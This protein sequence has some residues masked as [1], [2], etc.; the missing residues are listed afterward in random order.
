[1]QF[2]LPLVTQ[3]LS[4]F[5]KKADELNQ[6]KAGVNSF[7]TINI[8]QDSETGKEKFQEYESKVNDIITNTRTALE[9]E[10]I[11][12]IRTEYQSD[13][14]ANSTLTGLQKDSN[15]SLK[16]QAKR[17]MQ[18]KLIHLQIQLNSLKTNTIFN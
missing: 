8:T 6:Y 14:R 15:A 13:I 3:T 5:T 2:L 4:A 10:L 17:L 7:I 16:E 9:T 11:K 1:M 18:T 12:L